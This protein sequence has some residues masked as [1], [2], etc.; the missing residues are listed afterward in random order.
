MRRRFVSHNDCALILGHNRMSMFR[1]VAGYRSDGADL[2]Q[3]QKPCS[4]GPNVLGFVALAAGAYVELDGLTFFKRA[5]T[6][7]LDV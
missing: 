6:A 5:V 4:D 1:Q 2:K 7:A 3:A